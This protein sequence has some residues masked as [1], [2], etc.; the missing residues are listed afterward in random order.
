MLSQHCVKDRQGE[1]RTV[2]GE[3]VTS[4]LQ[5]PSSDRLSSL[6]MGV[7]ETLLFFGSFHKNIL[8]IFAGFDACI[9]WDMCVPSLADSLFL[10]PLISLTPK[11]N[12]KR[13]TRTLQMALINLSQEPSQG[14]A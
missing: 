8:E 6:G 3:A 4:K 9:Q 7:F 13:S 12:P 14:M 10:S 2:L 11:G 5:A 1:A